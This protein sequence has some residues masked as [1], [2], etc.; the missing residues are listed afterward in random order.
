MFYSSSI[1]VKNEQNSLGSC[2]FACLVYQLCE[3]C[4]DANKSFQANFD[5]LSHTGL[6]AKLARGIF[7]VVYSLV[8]LPGLNNNIRAIMVLNKAFS[9]LTPL[10]GG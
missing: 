5:V 7:L 6:S 9:V 2:F 8:E 10:L 4:M 1:V 3:C